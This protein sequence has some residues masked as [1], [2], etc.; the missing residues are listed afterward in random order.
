MKGPVSSEDVVLPKEGETS[1]DDILKA[2]KKQR[3]AKEKWKNWQQAR[4]KD[5]QKIREID[6]SENLTS[7]QK[8]VAWQRF[9]AAVSQ[10]NPYSRRDDE[11]RSFSRSRVL[12][13]ENLKSVKK[14]EPLDLFSPTEEITARDGTFITYAIGVVYDKNTGLEWYAGPDKD[15]TW[16]EAKRWVESLNVAGGSWH[17]P[18]REELKTVYKEGAGER[19]MTPLLKTTGWWVWSGETKGSSSA[20]GFAFSYGYE[21]WLYRDTSNDERGYA[22]R[23]RR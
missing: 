6:G 10:D 5:Y 7:K 13:W 20:W 8:T 9:L 12:H 3:Q 15:T 16:N 17:M 18:T 22:V 1:F 19:D 11:M 23:S 21:H 2:E 14:R 4:E